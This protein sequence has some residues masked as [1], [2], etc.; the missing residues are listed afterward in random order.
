MLAWEDKQRNIGFDARPEG[1]HVVA[2]VGRFK[3]NFIFISAAQLSL[4][5]LSKQHASFIGAARRN[6]S[7]NHWVIVSPV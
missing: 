5:E 1:L 7:Y 4:W 2:E 6:A 3:H